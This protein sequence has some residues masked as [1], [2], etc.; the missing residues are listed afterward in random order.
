MST[1]TPK[2]EA[3]NKKAEMYVYLRF[4]RVNGRTAKEDCY[5]AGYE[6]ATKDAQVLVDALDWYWGNWGTNEQKIKTEGYSVA[7]K[8]LKA[9]R[10]ENG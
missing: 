4:D 8:A 5:K 2:Q 1:L 6:Q 3:L 9:Y 10:G 7:E